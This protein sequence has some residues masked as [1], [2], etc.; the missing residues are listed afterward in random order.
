MKVLASAIL[1]VW[2]IIGLYFGIGGVTKL[3]SDETIDNIQKNKT[4]LMAKPMSQVL[5]GVTLSN[6]Y[7]YDLYTEHKG[8]EK[9]FFSWTIE[10]PKFTALLV[11]AMSFGLL[12]TIVALFK[13]LS[14]ANS[15]IINIKYLSQPLLGILT[16]LVV[17]G[18]SYVL[19]S[20]L[21]KSSNDI[22][23]ITLMFLCLFCGICVEK[24]YK[25]IDTSFEKLFSSK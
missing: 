22:R 9:S 24:F 18:L 8:L 23:P 4:D 19:P 20:L 16:G 2:L 17:L 3:S 6:Q 7:L 21:T 10:L 12:G 5:D 13:E 11:T 15:N 25:R 14:I 1:I